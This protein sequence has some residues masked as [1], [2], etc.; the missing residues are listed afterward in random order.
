[1]AKA[2]MASRKKVT[3]TKK[4]NRVKKENT[5]RP[6]KL[7]K[8][9]AF[10]CMGVLAVVT[11]VYSYL[12][13]E[14]NYQTEKDLMPIKVVE[15]EGELKH[16][17]R[18]QIMEKVFAVSNQPLVPDPNGGSRTEGENMSF[19]GTD[20][21]ELEEELESLPWLQTAELR[22]VWPDRLHLKLKEQTAIARWNDDSLI[23]EFG[24][25]FTPELADETAMHSLVSSPLSS[26]PLITGPD[27]ELKNLLT[28]FSDVQKLL[29]ANKLQLKIL[30]LN[31]RYAW[32]LELSNGIKIQIGR[33]NLMQRV[34]RFIA[35]YPLLQ[36]ESDLPIAKIDLR[37]DTGLA[38]Q[39]QK[40]TEL[41]A[42]L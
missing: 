9:T 2:K 26:L 28:T 24:N 37:Y 41:Q 15:I 21:I 30:N 23:N 5:L 42:S 12:W 31:H 29:E 11:M 35:L 18:E 13:I 25:I 39:R 36:S 1:M 40:P 16:I 32:S 14:E 33:K 4:V 6:V 22:R 27:S 7:L 19:F 20:L 17:T 38:V 34:E 10:L 8:N 3:V